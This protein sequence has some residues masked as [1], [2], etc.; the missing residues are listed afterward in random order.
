MSDL[1]LPR[2]ILFDMDGTL[3]DT[4][5]LWFQAESEILG[6]MGR[7]W[8]AGDEMA[9]IGLNLTDA[10]AHL[11][12]SLELDVEPARLARMLTDRVVDIGR[13]NGMPWRPGARELLELTATLGIPSALVTASHMPFARL[14]L[15]QAPPGTLS[16]AIT[17]D[18]VA[19]GKPHPQPYLMAIERLGASPATS[20]AFE[21][22]IHGLTSALAAGVVTVGVPLKVD[23]TGVENV[24]LIGSLGEVDENFLRAAMA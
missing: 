14:T 10:C 20:L 3:T 23:I 21:D 1:P 7:Q 6:D 13:E 5:A 16:V 4:E 22:S 17:G 9:V 15:D 8:K 11:V 2:A 12:S 19:I 24:R 18:Q